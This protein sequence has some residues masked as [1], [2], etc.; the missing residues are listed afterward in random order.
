MKKS[1]KN[2]KNKLIRKDCFLYNYNNMILTITSKDIIKIWLDLPPA[3]R[4]KLYL[5]GKT[6][7][8]EKVSFSSLFPE[9]GQ[10]SS[11]WPQY[12]RFKRDLPQLSPSG[13]EAAIM[14]WC[15]E[16]GV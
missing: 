6:Y 16:K 9:F 7:G 1:R 4:A 2:T 10:D 8:L 3:T 14:R 15:E 11:P 13:Y 12:E 5:A